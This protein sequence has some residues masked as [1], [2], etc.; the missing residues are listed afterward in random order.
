M[1]QGVEFNRLML[2]MRAMQMDA[3][4]RPKPA[5]APQEAGA[6]SFAEMGATPW[7]KFGG[8]TFDE[9][10][11]RTYPQLDHIDHRFIHKD[12]A[13]TTLMPERC[14]IL[15]HQFIN[16]QCTIT[17]TLASPRNYTSQATEL[18]QICHLIDSHSAAYKLL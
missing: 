14:G 15:N 1:S 8:E 12:T 13:V 18:S 17:L 2:E 16:G 4:A 6:P 10:C 3:M 7:D 11:L 5:A 9:M